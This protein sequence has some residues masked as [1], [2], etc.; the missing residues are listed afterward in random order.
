LVVTDVLGSDSTHERREQ[1]RAVDVEAG[2]GKRAR[3]Y[4]VPASTDSISAVRCSPES[5]W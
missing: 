3:K 2:V 5:V 4:T 1:D